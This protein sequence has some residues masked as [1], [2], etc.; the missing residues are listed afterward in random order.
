MNNLPWV[1]LLHDEM[2][3]MLVKIF[4][5]N[6]LLSTAKQHCRQC[7]AG[8]NAD[9]TCQIFHGQAIVGIVLVHDQINET[10]A[11]EGGIGFWLA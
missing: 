3:Q 8:C 11:R 4:E 5:R 1:C 10:Q 2:G 6:L 9:G 7:C